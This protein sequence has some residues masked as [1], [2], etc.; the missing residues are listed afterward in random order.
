M[1][2]GRE[3]IPQ[4]LEGESANGDGL[5]SRMW[6]RGASVSKAF[7]IALAMLLPVIATV[8]QWLL[9]D[10]IAP[11]VWFL[12]F[13]AVFFS[14]WLG[15]LIGGLMATGI[16]VLSAW[17][18]FIPPEYSFELQTHLQLVS[19]AMFTA[20]GCLFSYFHHCLHRAIRDN[21]QALST[22]RVANQ[23]ILQLYERTKEL[24]ELKTQFFANV[25][26]E[27]RTPL[28]LI[29]APIAKRLAIESLPESER[30]DLELVDRNAHL[31]YRHVSDLLDIAKLE[32][33]RMGMQYSRLDL[34]QILRFV[35]SHFEIL[36]IEKGIQF[37]VE[38]PDVVRVE[39]DAEKC[40]RIFLNLIGNAFKFTPTGGSITISLRQQVD[41]VTVHVA[42]SGPGVPLALRE[43]IFVPFRQG[44]IGAGR[45]YGGTGLGLAIVNDFVKLQGGRIWVDD[46]ETGGALFCIE[47][48]V[49]APK[50]VDLKE[51]S[52]DD[53]AMIDTQVI[54]ELYPRPIEAVV[55][56]QSGNAP[57]VLIV[58]DNPDMNRFL[59]ETLSLRYRTESAFD[60]QQ[61]LEKALRLRPDLIL[62]DVMMPRFSGDEMVLALRQHPELDKVPVVVLT[63]KA[64]DNL[65]LKL[66][67]NRAQDY[68][69]KPFVAEELLAKIDSLLAERRRAAEEL[70][71]S[72]SRYLTT[73]RS[74]G[75][76]VIATDSRGCITL[77]N[78]A[79][80]T[81]TGWTEEE[82]LGRPLSEVFVIIVESS[83]QPVE[84][85]VARVLREGCV[86]GLA[87]QTLLIARDG[88]ERPITD[89]CAPIRSA[90]GELMGAVL[91]FSDNT[92]E[93]RAKRAMKEKLGALQLL[94]AIING[95][96]DVI[97]AKDAEGRYILF[98]REASRFTGKSLESVIGNDDHAIFSPEQV[99]AIIASDRNVMQS[100]A[101]TTII[102]QMP[103]ID[104]EFTFMTTKGPLLDDR[105]QVCGLF[106][107]SR[108]ITT[109]K[110]TAEA[111]KQE[112]DRNRRYLDTVQAVMLALD[113]EGRVKMINRRGCELLGYAEGE[114][115]GQN[116]FEKCLPHPE[117]MRDVYPLFRKIIA[118][119]LEDV[120]Y[121]ESP[122][123]CGNG[124]QRLIAWHNACLYDN[125]G[126]A[127]GVL[128]A[129]EDITERKKIEAELRRLS[130]AVEQS[131]ESIV[132][133]DLCANIEYV[134]RA[135]LENT[136]FSAEE[137]IGQNVRILHSGK[138]PRGNFQQLWEALAEG[139]SWKGEFYNVRK[140]GS[141]FIEFARVSPI[142]EEDGSIRNYLSIKEDITEKKRLAEELDRHRHH[143]EELVAERTSK[144]RLSTYYL[145]ALIDNIP[146]LV[147]LKDREGRVLEVNRAMADACGYSMEFM[148]GKTDLELWPKDIAERYRADDQEVMATRRQK[149]I[150]EG[151]AMRPNAIFETYKAPVVD[152]DGAVLGT[153]G[154]SRDISHQRILE[155][156]R[157]Q[158]RQSAE[159]ASQAK[160]AFLA[161]MSHEIRTPMNAILGL[162]HLLQ[163]SQLTEGQSERLFKINAAAEHL[164]T[165]INDILDLSKIEAGRLTLEFVDFS[166]SALLD[167]VYSLVVEKARGKGLKITVDCE[168]VPL[169]LNGD[170]TRLSQALL[171]Y[172]SN[173]V[174]FTDK[175]TIVLRAKVLS[176][177]EGEFLVRFEVEDTG[178][179]IEPENLDK[180]FEAFEQ[181]DASTT[182]RYGG[183]GLGLTIT[184]RLAQ[185][186]GGEVGVQSR[187]GQGSLFWFT[188]KLYRGHVAISPEVKIV[189]S[190]LEDELRRYHAGARVLL[191]DDNE[192][193][194]EVAR[195][196]L[197]SVGLVVD[198][199]K[200][201]EEAVAKVRAGAYHLILM[202]MQMPKMSGL[203]ATS[204]I[205]GLSGCETIPIVAMTANAFAEDRQA[206][207][208]AGMSDFVAK[209][210][211]PASLYSTLMKWLPEN[212]ATP[213][214][215]FNH[216]KRDDVGQWQESLSGIVGLDFGFG[217]ALLHGQ[218]RKYWRLLNLFAE[219]HRN[220]PALFEEWLAA[221]DFQKIHGLAHSLK[222]S[223]GALGAGVVSEAAND[224]VA[225]IRGDFS[226]A[227]IEAKV[228]ALSA[229][230]KTLIDQLAAVVVPSVEATVSLD[231]ARLEQVLNELEALLQS[232]DIRSND[233]AHMQGEL[234]YSGLGENARELLRA[235]ESF[236][237]E[238]ALSVLTT[239]RRQ[240]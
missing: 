19:I 111:L 203:D 63:A 99:Q 76:G 3:T 33:G 72:E 182:R 40:R 78:S 47:L 190:A 230:L 205:R 93:Y 81:L 235:I 115:L 221:G 127:S 185:L 172:A 27:L 71:A 118:D 204:I 188:A 176:E 231:P 186:M 193:N 175:G 13:P 166:L 124:E 94:D 219:S 105:G 134:N 154:F 104:G 86:V 110:Q 159:A 142:R 160:S 198:V 140:D 106:G 200:D 191:V 30:R 236:D 126:R 225:A 227:E 212:I 184:R 240:G 213:V 2:A 62:T 228:N 169:W 143:L 65:R 117:G 85:S 146:Y 210:V 171:N 89:S 61:G 75:D 15:G 39:A 82:A 133:T 150:E 144:L 207:M 54:S 20:M 91:A 14:G 22:I 226:R 37:S 137:I 199:A 12:F 87:E 141:E 209:P 135:F 173:A 165:I 84:S 116:W 32:A 8:V 145:R 11:Y 216:G 183:T 4:R 189:K 239:L 113:C 67:Q 51:P 180:L 9:W 132:I 237:Y 201:G 59:V 120:G 153:A 114:L 220:D 194:S 107:I 5:K 192:V 109:L 164:L 95:S 31:L 52:R 41:R 74:I 224:L 60:G 178:I 69:Q 197:Y 50:G 23:E 195:E 238:K 214:Q 10:A 68:I 229:I 138:T 92:V 232:G 139:R 131:P 49:S 79:A 100:A 163:Q 168:D 56:P 80:E 206:C 218:G 101:S 147:W 64:D 170:S 211:V 90:I 234:I 57:L 97:Y 34:A 108:N 102:E 125:D 215:E 129:G 55:A 130:L 1:T 45:T 158:A 17:Y 152:E 26:H 88:T 42:D 167:N 119:V 66:L 136:G 53:E 6:Q 148:L 16:S 29:M 196:L 123:L 128:C 25:S 174:K 112:R 43:E 179:G 217:L 208:A 156:E 21:R 18:L 36:A 149:T 223:A 202:D 177:R 73:L 48:P 103:A 122:I 161:N 151:L 70:F 187:L 46:A 7:K 121:F 157:E 233:L 77:L 162:T 24:D 83:R 96:S 155:A 44:E 58:E 38:T 28:T 98:N 35:A 181:A 222:G